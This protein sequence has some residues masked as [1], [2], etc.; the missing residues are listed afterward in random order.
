[1]TLLEGVK[2]T[3]PLSAR[4]YY[5]N[6]QKKVALVLIIVSLSAFL[7][8]ALL[9]Y[10]ATWLKLAYA[11]EP[12]QS[13]IYVSTQKSKQSQLKQLLGKHP[14][15]A[16]IFLLGL[17]S[18]RTAKG[19]AFFFSLYAKDINPALHSLDLTLI[20]GRLPAAGTDE[21]V[22]HWR[23][24]ALKGLKLGDHLGRPYNGPNYK[25]VGLLDGDFIV[26]FSDLDTYF[27]GF[28]LAKE[29]IGFLVIP[30][31]GQ[32][33]KVVSFLAQCVRKDPKLYIF[34]RGPLIN[35]DLFVLNALY[36][37]I[38]CIVTICVSFLF[39]IY[40][41]QRCP[42]ICLLEALGYTRP[43]IIGKAFLEIS[44]I[45]LAGFILG[46]TACWLSGQ[47]L[48]SVAFV[49]QGLPLELWG[50][51]YPFKLLSTPLVIILSGL[52]IVWCM[53]KKAD[54]ISTIEGEV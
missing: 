5:C 24:A 4:K 41:Y 32:F 54:P 19:M 49:E 47:A 3:K 18:I 28:H 10:T 22:L 20:K 14:A 12:F 34:K 15:V 17:G 51:S 27:H 7:Q 21:M 50:I 45:S 46:L 6:N 40:F 48:N 53:L 36:L 33:D 25:L 39:Y 31:K 23:L 30:H 29:D 26:G 1:L 42:E 13:N 11:L 8:Y 37:A 2:M 38:T 16:K 35:T 52:L 44:G 9:I 43:M